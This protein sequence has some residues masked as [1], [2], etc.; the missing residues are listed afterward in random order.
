MN[1]EIEQESRYPRTRSVWFCER[2]CR[3]VHGKKKGAIYRRAL[4]AED[5]SHITRPRCNLG[6]CD[7]NLG[8]CNTA[9]CFGHHRRRLVLARCNR[10]KDDQVGCNC[11]SCHRRHPVHHHGRLEDN[12][13]T[14]GPPRYSCSKLWSVHHRIHRHHPDAAWSSRERD[15]PALRSCNMRDHP[16]LKEFNGWISL[17]NYGK[18]LVNSNKI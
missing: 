8:I 13:A 15:V 14:C 16:F 3:M 2:A 7:R 1:K 18:S 17:K 10:G 11:S 12:H 4:E 9:C 6:R 5:S